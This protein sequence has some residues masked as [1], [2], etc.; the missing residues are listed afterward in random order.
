M[1][2]SDLHTRLVEI[3]SDEE[4]KR[5][6]AKAARPGWWTIEDIDA[7][8]REAQR[9]WEAIHWEDGA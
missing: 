1:R 5:K 4:L 3:Q 6:A 2:R 7:A 8:G 9:L